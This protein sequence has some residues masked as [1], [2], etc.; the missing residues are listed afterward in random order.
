MGSGGVIN[1]TT[2]S[3]A[4]GSV[5]GTGTINVSSDYTNTGFGTGNS[6]NNHAGVSS[7]VA[8]DA[9]GNTAL[10][11]TGSQIS[12]STLNLGIVHAGDTGSATINIG[13]SG[14]T[15]P[16]LRGAVQNT[17]ITNSQLSLAA[18][19]YGPLSSG[20]STSTTLNY[21]FTSAGVLTSQSFRVVTNF[22]NVLAQ[23]IAV[24]GQV[25]NYAAIGMANATRGILTG[26]GSSFNL[27]L[28]NVSQGSGTIQ[29]LLDLLNAAVGPADNLSMLT[30]AF[31]VQNGGGFSV[32]IGAFSDL[33]AG[34]S[35]DGDLSISLDTSALG[36]MTETIQL[37]GTGSNASGWDSAF[38]VNDPTL[39]ITADIITNGGG[40]GGGSSV[41]EPASMLLLLPGL[42]ALRAV[43]RRRGG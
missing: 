41:P 35:D 16:S 2:L 5:T 7:N 39:T 8:I 43:R 30:N 20:Q 37:D 33:A 1:T 12:G 9:T 42:A 25:N 4:G 29:S 14:T 22:D 17:G 11:V 27:N 31:T 15:G 3:Q 40:G 34:D 36:L 10:S 13:N 18:S 26:G 24:T 38:G 23:T 28:G 6:F 32:G 19:N 21:N